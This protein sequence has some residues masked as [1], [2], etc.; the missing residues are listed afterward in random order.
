MFASIGQSQC[1]ACVA[2]VEEKLTALI[3]GR[4]ETFEPNPV[5]GV[6]RV[7]I[8][9]NRWV[10]VSLEKKVPHSHTH[11]HSTYRKYAAYYD[12]LD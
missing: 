8:L 3:E 9:H 6:L 10:R 11:E 4:L 7:Q 1:N 12:G 2:A 5:M